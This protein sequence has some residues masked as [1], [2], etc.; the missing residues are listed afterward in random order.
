MNP[1]IAHFLPIDQCTWWLYYYKSLCALFLSYL[2]ANILI[3]FSK[4]KMTC[5]F[6]MFVLLYNTV[7][8]W[9]GGGGGGI[10]RYFHVYIGWGHFWGFKILNFI[11]LGVFRKINI[12]GD[13]KILGSS[14][15]WTI[16]RDHFYTF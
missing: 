11:I 3:N 6:L 12:F 9:G 10:L 8:A 16:S 5:T 15:Y 2:F 13:T 7:Y 14:Q 4:K 1:I